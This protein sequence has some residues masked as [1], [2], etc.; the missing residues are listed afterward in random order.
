[1]FLCSTAQQKSRGPP[2]NNNSR[3]VYK[4]PAQQ[5][6]EDDFSERE[7]RKD[8]STCFQRKKLRLIY[9][10]FFLSPAP[11]RE[12][13]PPGYKIKP[14]M[15]HVGI[16]VSPSKRSVYIE[17]IKSVN[18]MLLVSPLPYKS[19][20]LTYARKSYGF[21]GGGLLGWREGGVLLLERREQVIYKG[22]INDEMRGSLV[23]PSVV[24]LGK[25]D[26]SSA[27]GS[28]HLSRAFS[29]N[30]VDLAACVC[31]YS[32]LLRKGYRHVNSKEYSR[33]TLKDSTN[34]HLFVSK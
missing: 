9:S 27:G 10:Y 2:S 7:C 19:I 28:D 6:A 15:I 12:L 25:S 14:R 20:L 8:G 21:T 17:R 22:I 33:T 23:I 31:V 30:D 5:R 11:E 24:F 3:I 26:A 13:G 18:K 4:S 29:S 34:L 32:Y 1:M 16:R